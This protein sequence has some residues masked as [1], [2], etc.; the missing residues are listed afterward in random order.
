MVMDRLGMSLE[1]Y[2]ILCKKKFS[3]KTI[4][5]LAL[6]MFDRIEYIHTKEIIHRDIK[7]DNYLMG[8][9]LK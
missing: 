6:Q 7:P 3:L 4:L 2:F 5:M 9:S 1:D 8:T